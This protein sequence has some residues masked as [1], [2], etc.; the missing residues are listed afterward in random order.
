MEAK[1]GLMKII[2]NLQ[3]RMNTAE[4]QKRLHLEADS[5]E[6]QEVE[7]MADQ[8]AALIRPKCAYKACYVQEKEDD[9]VIVEGV[10]LESRVLRKNLE[11]AERVFPFVI[12]IG[13]ELEEAARARDDYLEQYY[14]DTIANV[15]LQ[16]AIQNLRARLQ[17]QYQIDKLSY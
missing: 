14:M 13:A 1:T 3:W 12:T 11:S 2:D 15:A 16:D 7:A 9:A 8:A 10:R 4:I 5:R 6:W 17:D